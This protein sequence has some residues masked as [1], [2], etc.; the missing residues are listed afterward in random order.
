MRFLAEFVMRDRMRAVLVALLFTAI[1]L[2]GWVA[3]AIV[4]LVTL[5]K[6][7][8]EGALVLI[9]VI[10]P[11]T[12]LGLM[13]Y[14]QVLFYGVLGGTVTTYLG[15][16]LLRHYGSWAILLQVGAI[17]GIIAVV[18]VHILVPD[19][20]QS[21]SK[22]FA[23]YIQSMKSQPNFPVQAQDIQ[24]GADFLVKIA[25]GLQVAVLLLGNLFSLLVARWAQALLYH[26]DGLRQE[27]YNIRLGVVA[28]AVLG[29]I[30]LGSMGGVAAAIDSLPVI[31]LIFVVAG[32]SLVHAFFAAIN[33]KLWLVVF[34][35]LLVVL[36]PYMIGLLVILA[37]LDSWWNLRRRFHSKNIS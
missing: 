30:V 17:V 11:G 18:L 15:A 3:D 27:L 35:G 14:P 36:F 31:L 6:G 5:R 34:Y 4:A 10:L 9:W 16:V 25:T 12:V 8:R 1:P 2:F 37:L 13:G 21:W 20:A 33:Q 23:L 28:V 7:T 32:L 24:K 29:L 19:I 26:P 22:G